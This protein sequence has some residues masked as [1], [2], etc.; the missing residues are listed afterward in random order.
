M[1]QYSTVIIPTVLLF[2]EKD[3]AIIE[4]STCEES[5][6]EKKD[7]SEEKIDRTKSDQN[8]LNKVNN[9]LSNGFFSRPYNLLQFHPEIT[10]PPPELSL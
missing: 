8:Q 2:V 6:S 10:T 3:F 1:C 4:L 5:E 9:Y 7:K